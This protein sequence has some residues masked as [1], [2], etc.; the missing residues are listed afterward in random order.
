MPAH[1]RAILVD[2]HEKNLD[3]TVAHRHIDAA[4][5]FKKPHVKVEHVVEDLVVETKTSVVE[6]KTSV[7]DVKTPVVDENVNTNDV[8]VPEPTQDV[9]D[10]VKSETVESNDV[11]EHVSDDKQVNKL[12]DSN[13]PDEE[14]STKKSKRSKKK[15]DQ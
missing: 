14:K 6:T 7:E 11:T 3:P 9:S 8:M 5:G 15:D 12:D 4:G 13:T 10:V 1:R 2:I